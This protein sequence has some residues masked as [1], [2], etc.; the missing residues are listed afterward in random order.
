MAAMLDYS[1]L[2]MIFAIKLSILI[3]GVKIILDL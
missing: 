1:G 3:P 2:Y